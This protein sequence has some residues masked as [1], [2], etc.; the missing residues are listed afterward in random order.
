M[1][2]KLKYFY[3][4][5]EGEFLLDS[6]A[7]QFCQDT[8]VQSMSTIKAF[9]T[10]ENT[11]INGIEIKVFCQNELNRQDSDIDAIR[12]MMT[13][14]KNEN[15]C[16]FKL[17]SSLFDETDITEKKV[18]MLRYLLEN[19][20]VSTRLYN[21]RINDNGFV[22][23]VH[24]YWGTYNYKYV[25]PKDVI[26]KYNKYYSE[27]GANGVDLTKLTQEE[28]ATYVIPH[29]YQEI[30]AWDRQGL[31]NNTNIMSK[32]SIGWLE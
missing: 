4:V 7:V 6:Q 27:Y 16:T 13:D 2:I 30:G 31:R 20:F 18:S 23:C 15:S 5:A 24:D 19:Y 12:C 17:L 32:L 21:T 22:E 29:Y 9:F 26:M 28:L 10:S 11:D 25:L 14:I 1:T 3:N 8:F